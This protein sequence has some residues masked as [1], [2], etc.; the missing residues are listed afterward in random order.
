MA[1]DLR[2][3]DFDLLVRLRLAHQTAQAA[4]G[5]RK[6][7][8]VDDKDSALKM[9]ANVDHAAIERS[10]KR[11][12]ARRY[13]E[14]IKEQ[15]DK[16]A[17]PPTSAGY[18]RSIRWKGVQAGNSLNAAKAAEARQQKVCPR[19]SL[20]SV[21]PYRVLT[22]R[23]FGQALRARSDAYKKYH[24]DEGLIGAGLSDE[25]L[26][27]HTYSGEEGCE[28]GYVMFGGKVMLAK[29]AYTN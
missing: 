15:Q 24:I 14:I 22:S 27:T 6:L 18:D 7:S 2:S 12:L 3:V 26:L 5:T 10:N 28:W 1:D 4:S 23:D 13:A 25:R 21:N 9:P 19:I 17:A 16:G 11:L 20:S 8:K 29:G